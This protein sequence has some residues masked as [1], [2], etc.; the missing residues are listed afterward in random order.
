MKGF[1]GDDCDCPPGMLSSSMHRRRIKFVFFF[2]REWNFTRGTILDVDRD[3]LFQRHI[4]KV[5]VL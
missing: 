4:L 1:K 2:P 5:S 3:I